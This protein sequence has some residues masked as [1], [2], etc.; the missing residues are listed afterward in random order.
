ME[1]LKVKWKQISLYFLIFFDAYLDL[2]KEMIPFAEIDSYGFRRMMDLKGDF[3]MIE[4]KTRQLG[5]QV[6]VSAN[7]Y[8]LDATFSS[9]SIGFIDDHVKHIL[10]NLKDALSKLKT[11]N[12]QS[13]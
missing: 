2:N 1:K 5:R 11:N 6:E 4:T 3:E 9:H 12:H 13:E 8:E 10:K 7:I